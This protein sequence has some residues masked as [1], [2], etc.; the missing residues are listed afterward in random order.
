MTHIVSVQ[1]LHCWLSEGHHQKY[2]DDH[3]GNDDDGDEDDNDDDAAYDDEGHQ[4]YD[5]AADDDDH[6]NYDDADCNDHNYQSDYK[7]LHTVENVDIYIYGHNIWAHEPPHPSH[8]S[9]KQSQFIQTFTDHVCPF[10][11]VYKLR[12]YTN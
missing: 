5:D 8:T 2:N 4:N 6:Q 9:A 12:M 1:T 7:R 3:D 10:S 11:N